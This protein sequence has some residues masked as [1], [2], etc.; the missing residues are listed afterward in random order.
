MVAGLQL[1]YTRRR[2]PQPASQASSRRDMPCRPGS[3]RT[4]AAQ[5]MLLRLMQCGSD[6]TRHCP[7]HRIT[8]NLASPCGAGCTCMHSLCAITRCQLQGEDNNYL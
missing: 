8:S 7:S 2:A 3:V 4:G 6:T 1:T 5:V